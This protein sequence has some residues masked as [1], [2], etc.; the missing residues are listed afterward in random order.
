MAKKKNHTLVCTSSVPIVQCQSCF[1]LVVFGM[2]AAAGLGA[3][4]V[5][6]FAAVD[7]KGLLVAAKEKKGEKKTNKT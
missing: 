2:T 5:E 4:E 7:A 6:G 1:Y 3:A